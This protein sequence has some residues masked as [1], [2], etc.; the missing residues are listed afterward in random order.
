M[1]S[2]LANLVARKSDRPV[3]VLI[4]GIEGWGKSTFGDE[5]PNPVFISPEGGCDNL[6]NA[7]EMP[8]IKTF[9]DVKEAV[10]E[11][12]VGQHDFKTLVLDSADW[13]EKL[14][15]AQIVGKTGKSITT[16]NGGYGAG[17]RQSELMH[18]E[19]IEL[20]SE[21]REKRNMNIIVTAHYQVKEVK[22]PGTLH[23]Y[24]QFE[25]KCHEMV[26]SLF[27]EWVDAILFCRFTTHV[28]GET[29]DSKAIATGDG[30]RI[31]FTEHRPGYQ[32]KNRFG[33]PPQLVIPKGRSWSTFESARKASKGE[34][35][36]PLYREA[37]Q[38]ASVLD[39]K[40]QD[41]AIPAIELSKNNPTELKAHIARLSS[42]KPKGE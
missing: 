33:L 28:K 3:R 25:I 39:P 16:A 15:H 30:E 7:I 34:N 24:D 27:R 17:Y 18:R 12:I 35:P 6:V 21:L 4:Y 8:N 42:L 22:D 5:S 40:I 32:A 19:L 38:L 23:S 20:L 36:E 2:R 9:D 31:M 37:M 26:S 14:C 13:I 1:S 29:D 11:L 10:K 41:K